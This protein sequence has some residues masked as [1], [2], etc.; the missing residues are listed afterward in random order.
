LEAVVV[1]ANAEVAATAAMTP[2][3]MYFFMIGF[4]GLFACRLP[5][6]LEL[7]GTFNIRQEK[8]API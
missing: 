2:V 4:V 3:M 6:D 1:P 7:R 8:L 5:C